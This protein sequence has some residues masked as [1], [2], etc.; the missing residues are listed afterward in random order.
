MV[1][2][3]SNP[4]SVSMSRTAPSLATLALR[5]FLPFAFVYFLAYIYRGVNAVIFPYLERDIGITAADLG[6]LTSGFFLFFAG[7]QPILGVMLDRYGPR[8]VQVVLMLAAAAGSALFALSDALPGLIAARMLIGLGFAGGLMAAIKAITLWYPPQRW[9]HVTGYHMT[10]GGLGAMAGTW[11]VQ[12][13]LSFVTWQGLFFWLAGACLLAGLII[14]LAVPERPNEQAPGSIQQQFR[15]IG[16]VLGDGFFWRIQ[17]LFTFQQ[18]A[19][20]ACITLWIGPWL[21]DVGGVADPRARA[22]LQLYTMTAMTIGFA[23]SGALGAWF[24]LGGIGS[25]ASATIMTFLFTLV[26]G[27][28]AFLPPVWPVLPWLL[29]GFLGA[30][31]IQFMP[32]LARSFPPHL[33]GRVS[34]SCNL[35]IFTLVFTGQWAIGKVVDHWPRTAAGYSPDGYTW[36]LGTLFFLQLAGLAWMVVSQAHPLIERASAK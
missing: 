26:C 34:T 19:F 30:Y 17:P 16:T 33:A 11:P 22:D 28:L 9:G 23:S 32:L 21:R 20:I 18:F 36:S 5:I 7:C 31:P 4:P 2:I 35:A 24:R 10:A 14:L 3:A 29:F 25:F 6:L 13:S 8:R 15:A 27:W 1:C 12:W